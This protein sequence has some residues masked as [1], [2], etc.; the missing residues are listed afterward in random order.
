MG[1]VL[2]ISNC[3]PFDIGGGSFATRAYIKAFSEVLNEESYIF[4]PEEG[5]KDIDTSMT[6]H[7][8]IRVKKRKLLNKAIAFITGDIQRYSSAVKQLT[9][10]NPKEFTYAICNGSMSSGALVEFLHSH[11]IKV[12]TIHHNFE[13]EY[14]KDNPTM[15]HLQSLFLYHISRRERIAYK[16]SD[17]NIFLT[18]DD[19]LTFERIYGKSLGINATLGVFEF[20]E[21]PQLN[22]ISSTK[23]NDQLSFVITGQLCLEQGID[24]IMYFFD[25][26]Y[27]YL[28]ANSRVI[29]AGRNPAEILIKECKKHSNVTLISNPVNIQ[30][31]IE[32]GDVYICPTRLGGGLKLRIMDGLRVGL[33]VI[34]HE[35]SARGY[36]YLGGAEYFKVF[37]NPIEFSE[38][39]KQILILYKVGKINKSTIYSEY[40]KFF[41]YQSGVERIHTLLSKERQ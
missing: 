7:R 8:Y 28:P 36:D 41:S 31:I 25:E 11:N 22:Q 27:Q 37:S 14:F 35:C 12:I 4:L 39:I 13:S 33:P 38:C 3:D 29:I 26:L 20:K 34:T 17:L 5:V 10:N 6:G 9:N 21:I 19:Q 24:S 23:E 40:S 2:F 18:K 30:E 16:K 15:T 1:K 32:Q